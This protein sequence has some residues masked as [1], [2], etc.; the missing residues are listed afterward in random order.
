MEEIVD[1][2]FSDKYDSDLYKLLSCM[3]RYLNGKK[4]DI[5]L[6]EKKLLVDYETFISSDSGKYEYGGLWYEH[7]NG[8][9]ILKNENKKRIVDR[10]QG[11]SLKMIT[12]IFSIKDNSTL[13]LV[14]C[15]IN[16]L[17]IF[18]K[19]L[20]LMISD[21]IRMLPPLKEEFSSYIGEIS[22]FTNALLNMDE[23]NPEINQGKEMMREGTCTREI[24]IVSTLM[25]LTTFIFISVQDSKDDM[26]KTILSFF[27]S[28][29]V[30]AEKQHNDFRIELNKA[31]IESCICVYSNY[32]KE[33]SIDNLNLNMN[34]ALTL[35]GELIQLEND[36]SIVLSEILITNILFSID[37]LL[38]GLYSNNNNTGNNGIIEELEYIRVG[39]TIKFLH[40][41]LKLIINSKVVLK[42]LINKEVLTG[43][44]EYV[45]LSRT[46]GVES[47][48][49]HFES[50]LKYKKIISECLRS[51]ENNIFEDENNC[52]TKLMISSERHSVEILQKFFITLPLLFSTS[53]E[54][55]FKVI[56]HAHRIIHLQNET[57]DLSYFSLLFP[58]VCETCCTMHADRDMQLLLMS[59]ILELFHAVADIMESSFKK[60]E[61]HLFTYLRQNIELVSIIHI[62]SFTYLLLLDIHFLLNKSSTKSVNSGSFHTYSC[63]AGKFLSSFLIWCSKYEEHYILYYSAYCITSNIKG[64]LETGLFSSN[65]WIINSVKYLFLIM[66]QY[67]LSIGKCVETSYLESYQNGEAYI[68]KKSE[69]LQGF[70]RCSTLSDKQIYCFICTSNLIDALNNVQEDLVIG[71]FQSKIKEFN[72]ILSSIIGEV[73]ENKKI[74]CSKFLSFSHIKNILM[75]LPYKLL[76]KMRKNIDSIFKNVLLLISNFELDSKE[77]LDKIPCVDLEIFLYNSVSSLYFILTIKSIF[78]YNMYQVENQL[79]FEEEE[80]GNVSGNVS[81]CFVFNIFSNYIE[82]IDAYF[83][84]LLEFYVNK[85]IYSSQYK[86]S[87]SMLIIILEYMASIESKLSL[88][89]KKVQKHL[90]SFNQSNSTNFYRKINLSDN[91]QN[92]ISCRTNCIPYHDILTLIRFG[93]VNNGLNK[94]SFKYNDIVNSLRS[95][96]G[97]NSR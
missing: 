96:R 47:C 68:E 36:Y 39:V 89:D 16:S 71:Y 76:V 21:G 30:I 80:E 97:F 9:D 23:M 41:T 67:C 90:K 19:L 4:Y 75:F 73:S 86:E 1:F 64:I 84:K 33:C 13:K 91:P 3:N 44:I 59:E 49:Q 6:L 57:Y 32:A 20:I 60:S 37:K 5:K 50:K 82:K 46:L 28:I 11:I 88:S 61:D 2:I 54:S 94:H 62:T 87:V 22:S 7:E 63:K 83:A 38:Y 25:E 81:C 51:T 43:V 85:G 79:D 29:K 27:Q 66:T 31:L 72:Q 65:G 18:L 58:V 92:T 12:H 69:L 10:Y 55:I 77:N 53:K 56:N 74:Q 78:H 48:E 95:I 35:A 70:F 24:N 14:F 34:L 93:M 45:I 26:L 52:Y 15:N 8:L 40:L 42:Q 17:Y